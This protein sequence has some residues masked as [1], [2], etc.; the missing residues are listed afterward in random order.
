LAAERLTE[1]WRAAYGRGPDPSVAWSNAVK[2]IEALLQP[3]VSP[4]DQA[5]T[6]GKMAQAM[7]DKPEKWQFVLADHK[8]HA[9]ASSFLNVLALIRYEPGRHGSDAGAP[10]LEQARLVVLQTVV[11][12]EALRMGAL[13]RV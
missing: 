13:K 4:D 3:I 6:L 12:V 9:D 1:A 10:T 2:S 7:R 8:G 11:V 5:A